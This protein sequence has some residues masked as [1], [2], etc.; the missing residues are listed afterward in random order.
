MLKSKRLQILFPLLMGYALAAC[1]SSGGPQ[2]NGN[3]DIS[4]GP[5]PVE[6][7]RPIHADGE[8]EFDEFSHV[9][10]A[11]GAIAMTAGA[12]P[13]SLDRL[14]SPEREIIRSEAKGEYRQAERMY[15]EALAIAESNKGRNHP[16]V[17]EIRM[18][19]ANLYYK[20]GKLAESERSFRL[21]IKIPR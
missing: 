19:L 5:R 16:R 14:A 13:R 12:G 1:G 7:F 17:A 8:N 21:A 6:N 11:T 9:E 3:S 15:K 4:G 18:A 20:Q 10:P 2:N